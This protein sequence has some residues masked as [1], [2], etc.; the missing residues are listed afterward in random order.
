MGN[1]L[2]ENLGGGR[3]RDIT[4]EADLALLTNHSASAV[5]F[6]YDRD[7]LLDLFVCNVGVYTTEE[8]GPGDFYRSATNTIGTWAL[9]TL[10]IITL[11]PTS[12]CMPAFDFFRCRASQAP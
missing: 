10:T 1:V 2:Y 7:G 8:K 6:D 11:D 3:F 9:S 12:T 5:F 4:R